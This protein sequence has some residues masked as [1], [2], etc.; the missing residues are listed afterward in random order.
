MQLSPAMCQKKPYADVLKMRILKT[1]GKD[2]TQFSHLKRGTLLLVP[3]NILP[4][5]DFHRTVMILKRLFELSVNI[6][7]EKTLSL[8]VYQ[9]KNG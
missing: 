9:E 2:G 4:L 6:W 8:M 3:Y 1:E 5:V 7:R